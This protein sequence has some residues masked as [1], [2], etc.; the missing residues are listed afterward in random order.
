MPG[1]GIGF[2]DASPGTGTYVY[3]KAFQT[4]LVQGQSSI[5]A[6]TNNTATT[7]LTVSSFGG[8]QISTDTTHQTIYF[9]AGINNINILSN[10]ST[11]TNNLTSPYTSFPITSLLSTL[12]L[13]G[14]GDL[15]L[16]PGQ[17]NTVFIGI[18]GFTSQGYQALSGEV[19]TL[20]SSILTAASTLYVNKQ[21]YNSGISSFS[22]SIGQ[23]LSSYQIS[24][25]YLA[26]SSLANTNISTFST[27][28]SSLAGSLSLNISTLSSYYYTVNQSTLSTFIFNSLASTVRGY[29]TVFN[30]LNLSTINK[31]STFLTTYSYTNLQHFSTAGSLISN[32]NFL[33]SNSQVLNSNSLYSLSNRL[34]SNT[35]NMSL[36]FSTLSTILT[37][38]FTSLFTPKKAL[39][40]SLLYSGTRGDNISFTNSTGGIYLTTLSLN[41]STA[42]TNINSLAT[43]VS[44]EYSPV[45]LFP[46]A[47]NANAAAQLISTYIT[48]QSTIPGAPPTITNTIIP[49]TTFSDYMSWNQYSSNSSAP[50]S[51][52]YSRYLRLGI[53][54]GFLLKNTAGLY[55]VNHA[56][57]TAGSNISQ[58]ATTMHIRNS[59][60][61][62]A[63][64]NIFN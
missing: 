37:S 43:S 15:T 16:T 18:Q 23:Q 12:T 22:T 17:T 51:N 25:T 55:I 19:F 48:Y 26:L 40:S 52:V 46:M 53:S 41:M 50:L 5:T 33:Y 21:D 42:I 44:L 59:V 1:N 56:L 47:S 10:T 35:S 29:S 13:L 34:N 62:S 4:F 6:F 9:K 36:Y 45:L 3:S 7:S 24:S 11:F 30:S 28:Y 60:Q 39:I 63:F 32:Y 58:T 14:T 61:N 49:N 54:T 20:K 8:L 64:L 27:L 57:P 31:F 38:S 2:T